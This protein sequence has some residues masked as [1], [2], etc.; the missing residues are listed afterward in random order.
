LPVY[1]V[2]LRQI[3]VLHR[4]EYLLGKAWN[5]GRI[6]GFSKRRHW[7]MFRRVYGLE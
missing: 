2:I 1:D 6:G 7:E 4:E 3:A 5:N